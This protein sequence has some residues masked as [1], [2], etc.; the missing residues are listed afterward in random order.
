MAV[1]VVVAIADFLCVSLP[2][3]FFIP[4]TK[5]G[6]YTAIGV[7]FLILVP[8]VIVPLNA[9]GAEWILG[10]PL[11]IPASLAFLLYGCFHLTRSYARHLGK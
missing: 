4:R 9:T 1:S 3:M 2:C 5:Q 8:S 6:S 10:R 7:G 11:T